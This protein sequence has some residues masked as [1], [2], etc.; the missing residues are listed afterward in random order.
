M[1]D[2]TVIYF[3]KIISLSPSTDTSSVNAAVFLDRFLC[4]KRRAVK[5]DEGVYIDALVLDD[6][7]GSSRLL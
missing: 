4:S 6:E 3:L 5:T 7:T 1:V 2:V